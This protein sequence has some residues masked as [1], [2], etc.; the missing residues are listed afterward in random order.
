MVEKQSKKVSNKKSVD[1]IIDI[2]K[3]LREKN[4]KLAKYV[5]KAFIAY[6]ERITH[7]TMLNKF[8]VENANIEGVEFVDRALNHFGVKLRIHGIEN[9][10]TEEKLLIASNHPLGGLDSLGL[11]KAVSLKRDDMVFLVNDILMNLPSLKS[12]FV[13]VNKHGSQA[14]EAIRVFGE[15]M[16]SDRTVLFFPAGLVSRKIKG[17]I[18]D[19]EWKKTFVTKSR[20]SGRK[21]IPVYIDGRNSNFF[22]NLANLRKFLGIKSNIE[23]LYLVDEMY[24]QYNKVMHIYFGEPISLSEMPSNLKDNAIAGMIKDYVYKLPEKFSADDQFI[25]IDFNRD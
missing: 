24:K 7:L 18:V 25:S 16:N 14:K 12:S 4:P 13:P 17:K 19:L 11:M 9:I 20:T 6:L 21:I 22:Y 2:E 1:K 5:P 3:V 10:L 23:M 8:L 15:V